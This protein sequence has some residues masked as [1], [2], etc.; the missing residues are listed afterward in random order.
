MSK[1]HHHPNEGHGDGGPPK[2][3]DQPLRHNWF[4]YVAGF[5]LIVALLG[6][7]WE[8]TLGMRPVIPPPT[9]APASSATPK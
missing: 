2:L 8:G 4:F 9:T 7:I 6:F 3:D 1:H 5:F